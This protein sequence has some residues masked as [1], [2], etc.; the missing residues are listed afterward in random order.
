MLV[1]TY[2]KKRENNKIKDGE[3]GMVFWFK[4]LFIYKGRR[5]FLILICCKYINT[6]SIKV[7]GLPQ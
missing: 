6:Y 1:G 3:T 4:D 5:D 2:V 7:K